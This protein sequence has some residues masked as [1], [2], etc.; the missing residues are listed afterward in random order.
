MT[1]RAAFGLELRRARE[2]AGLTLDQIAEATKISASLFAG[3]E[4]NDFSR[5]PSGIFRRA[6]IRSY[7]DTVGLDPEEVVSRFVRLFPEPGDEPA[8]PEDA[9][10]ASVP[11]GGA[12]LR[13]V[14]DHPAPRRSAV[15]ART[16]R[17]LGAAG[18]DVLVALLPAAVV[19]LIAGRDWFWM[20][21]FCIGLVGHLASL[22][23]LGATPGARLLLHRPAPRPLLAPGEEPAP[24]RR[25]LDDVEIARRQAL[26][27]HAPAGTRPARPRRVQR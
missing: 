8:R 6:F 23:F 1:E 25:R 2:H 5:W 3:L 16:A 27:H 21:A 9:G 26:R 17:G 12:P 22:A 14:L 18:I 15:V 20:S 19:S 4:R 10:A 7:A 13:L 24:V 11:Q